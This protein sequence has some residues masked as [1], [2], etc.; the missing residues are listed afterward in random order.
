MSDEKINVFTNRELSWLQFN[1][2]VLEEA[3]KEQLP[4]FERL[5]FLSIYMNNLDEFYRVRVGRLNDQL[6]LDDGVVASQTKAEITSLFRTVLRKTKRLIPRFDRAYD[7]VSKQLKTLGV[8]QIEEDEK[9][10]EKDEAFLRNVFKYKVAPH[11]TPFIVEKNHPLPFFENERLV[12]GVTLKTKRGN[13]R[14]GF[15]PIPKDVDKIVRIPSD[16][17]RYMLI[18]DLIFRYANRIFHKFSVE[19]KVVFSVVR[20]ADIDESD[21]LYDYDPD[22]SETMSKIIEVR[23]FRAPVMVKY[24]G[25]NTPKMLNYLAHNFALRKTQFFEYDSPLEFDHLSEIEEMMSKKMRKKALFTPVKPAKIKRFSDPSLDL[26]ASLLE[27]DYLSSYPFESMTPMI[28][29]LNQAAKDERVTQISMTLYRASRQSKIV[30]GL[31]AASKK[32]KKVTVVIELRARFDEE[33]NIDLSEKLQ[34]AGINVIYGLPGYKVHSKLLLIELSDQRKIALVGTGN[35]NETTARFYTDLALMTADKV[36]TDDV[37]NVFDNI[38]AGSFV[39]QSQS[40]LVSPL[41]M[42]PK[43]I[44]LIDEEI[45]F[46]H[47]GK[48]ARIVMKMNSLTEKPMMN[49]LIEA[50]QA[51]VKI[52]LII[53]GIC[54]LIPGVKG[55]TD[56]IKVRSIVG[57]YLEHSRIFAFGSAD[58]PVKYYISSADLMTRNLTGRVEAAAPIYDK[59]NQIK[60]QNILDLCLKDNVNARI[61]KSNGKYVSVKAGKKEKLIDSQEILS[62]LAQAG[63]SK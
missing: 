10:S 2:R 6:I 32:G 43:L 41:L 7:E 56:N 52:D 3:E 38:A 45:E 57:R 9:I 54:C 36:I 14:F 18:E 47:H 55:Q 29:L 44:E 30:S 49:K 1:E 20:N 27:K 58:R 16:P 61:Q 23:N 51:G 62:E 26:I 63:Q 17:R 21:G 60:I 24:N 40:L 11:L 31:I 34:K 5:R 46:A 59:A 22:F 35:F 42:K 19:G 25:S 50:S 37:K 8:S 28:N 15:L 53:R 4:T 33:N 12:L 39:Q 48:P 13:T